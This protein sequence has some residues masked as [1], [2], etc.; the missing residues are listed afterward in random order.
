MEFEVEFGR[1]QGVQGQIGNDGL[2]KSTSDFSVVIEVKTTEV[3]AVKTIRSQ[4]ISYVETLQ[5]L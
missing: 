3:Y 4:V 2:W 1:Y 5:M